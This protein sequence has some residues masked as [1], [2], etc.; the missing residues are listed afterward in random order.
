MFGRKKV[1]KLHKQKMALAAKVA[2][3]FEINFCLMS[4]KDQ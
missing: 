3:K 4:S 2:K 1:D